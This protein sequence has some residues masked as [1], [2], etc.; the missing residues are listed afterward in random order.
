MF[1][2]QDSA[3]TFPPVRSAP[4]SHDI[5]GTILGADLGSERV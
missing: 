5:I 1:S 4:S 2:T 3:A